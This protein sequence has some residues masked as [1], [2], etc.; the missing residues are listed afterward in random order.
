MPV[1]EIC[2]YGVDDAL[3]AQAAGADRIELC[4]SPHEGG[5]TPSYGVLK[6][7]KSLLKIPV[8]PMVR[9][10]GGD[11]CYSANEFSAML[12]DIR[13]I[14][15]LGYPGVVTGLL[16]LDGHLDCPKMEQVV[17]VAGKLEVTFHRAFDQCQSPLHTCQQL[18]DVGVV[19]LLTSGQ[20]QYAETGLRLLEQLNS[21]R[22]RPIIMVGSGVRLT[23][24]H[25]FL[26]CGLTEFHSSAGRQLAS[27]VRFSRPGVSLN[28]CVECEEFTRIGV[29]E[30]MI[31]A[32]K[33]LI[34]QHQ[35][36]KQN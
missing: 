25:K 35:P 13:Y 6:Q 7:A 18:A 17:E 12:D 36:D 10:R 27:P 11:F 34:S 19:R 2:C 29:D 3:T 20:Q 23:N 4:A 1:L 16:D 14:V 31:E 21:L 24:L 5:L 15:E 9:P 22:K 32:M 28:Y 26:D 33:S 8:H 30:L